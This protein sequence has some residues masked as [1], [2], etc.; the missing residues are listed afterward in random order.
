MGLKRYP[1]TTPGRRHMVLEDK[2][3]VTTDEP[4]I[5]AL[6]RPLKKHAGRN[7]QG[8]ITVRHRG[9][10]AKRQYRIIDFRRDKDGVPATVMT[11]EYDPN[12][13]CRIALLKY[14]DGEYRYIL[15]PQ[16]LEVGMQV[17]SGPDAPIAP[18][19]A[20][21][22]AAIPDGTMVHNLE[23]IPGRGGQ[24][25]RSAGT[26]AQVMAKEGGYVLVRLP[27]GEIRRFHQDCKATIG[28]LSVPEHSLVRSGKAGRSRWLGIRPTVRGT[29]MNPVDH[30]HGGG[31]GRTKGRHPVSPW[32]WCTKGMKTRRPGKPSDRFIVSRRQ[33]KRKKR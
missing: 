18:G 28:E 1:P 20:L 26:S 22:L 27:S 2:A 17:L 23:L 32:G 33:K 8:R 29:A 14:A 31:E 25:V 12:R 19:N 21:P 7:S 16:G 9:G 11:I 4:K 10:G 5:K 30:P 6:L 24:L 15:A 3:E 13:S